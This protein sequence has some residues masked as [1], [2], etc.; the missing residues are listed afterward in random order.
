LQTLVIGAVKGCKLPL[1]TII[2]G[3]VDGS[4]RPFAALH[5]L[6]QRRVAAF[7]LLPFVEDAAFSTER[8]HQADIT[9]VGNSSTAPSPSAKAR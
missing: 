9:T 7:A 4:F 3:N 5:C 2:L 6:A 8:R 1:P